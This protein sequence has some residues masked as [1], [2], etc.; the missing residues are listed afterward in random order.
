MTPN[1]AGRW[2]AGPTAISILSILTAL[3]PVGTASG[4]VFHHWADCDGVLPKDAPA[5]LTL[6]M[7][8]HKWVHLN[9]EMP[10]GDKG[11]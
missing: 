9:Y 6:V 8:G 2:S 4:G 7:D 5:P 10:A 3:A 1:P 11:K